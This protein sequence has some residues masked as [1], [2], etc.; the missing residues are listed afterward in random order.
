MPRLA[1]PTA[2]IALKLTRLTSYPTRPPVT[3]PPDH[4]SRRPTVPSSAVLQFSIFTPAISTV[5]V[6]LA[7]SDRHGKRTLAGGRQD[8]ESLFAPLHHGVLVAKTHAKSEQLAD[9]CS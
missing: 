1:W 7:T 8:M 4:Y 5:D 3:A 6:A 2:S 9:I